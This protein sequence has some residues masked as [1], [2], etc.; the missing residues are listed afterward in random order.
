MILDNLKKY[1][2]DPEDSKELK[3]VLN[4]EKEFIKVKKKSRFEEYT[5]LNYSDQ[6]FK[7]GYV[8]VDEKY[9]LIDDLKYNFKNNIYCLITQYDH[10][11]R[12]FEDYSSERLS[13]SKEYIEDGLKKLGAYVCNP[14]K[15]EQKMYI[16]LD[17]LTKKQKKYLKTIEE[18][19]DGKK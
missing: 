19:I 3:D 7:N 4:K 6:L 11:N 18:I 2:K 17:K 8:D 12:G 15:Y 16:E 9:V 5:S 13:K 1:I 10:I 14:K